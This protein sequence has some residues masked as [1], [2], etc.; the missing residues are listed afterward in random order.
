MASACGA[1]AS[2]WV[3]VST[4]AAGEGSVFGV[5]GAGTGG[6]GGAAGGG[7]AA[8]CEAGRAL[9]CSAAASTWVGVSPEVA[10]AA[11]GGSGGAASGRGDRG[12]FGSPRAGVGT[13][14]STAAGSA[15]IS[16]VPRV[17][18]WGGAVHGRC[19][20]AAFR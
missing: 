15:F 11:G 9:A 1:A 2:S 19:A 3:G 17:A 8:C 6:R 12:G 10:G 14:G 5:D 20:A 18:P 4:D 13:S 7:V 16:V